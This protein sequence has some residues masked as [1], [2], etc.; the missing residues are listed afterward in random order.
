MSPKGSPSFFDIL[1]FFQYYPNFRRFVRTKTR[2]TKMKAEV[3]KHL[4]QHGYTV[5]NT[6]PNYSDEVPIKTLILLD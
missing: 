5:S 4:S 6:E 1:I 2:F 3:Q